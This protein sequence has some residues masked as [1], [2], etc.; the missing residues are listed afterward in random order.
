VRVQVTS[1]KKRQVGSESVGSQVLS[2]LVLSGM[3]WP[4]LSSREVGQEEDGHR[5]CFSIHGV[6]YLSTLLQTDHGA[7][8]GSSDS[9]VICDDGKRTL[10]GTCLV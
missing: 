10:V 8:V 5:H 4:S 7:Q 9:D 3:V 1:L 2:S 6:L